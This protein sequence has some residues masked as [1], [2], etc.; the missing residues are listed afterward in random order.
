MHDLAQHCFLLLGLNKDWL[1]EQVDLDFEQQ[2]VVIRLER[3]FRWTGR[4]WPER[5]VDWA[6][7]WRL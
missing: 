4:D 7:R 1:V 6:G 5:P 3:E 2:G